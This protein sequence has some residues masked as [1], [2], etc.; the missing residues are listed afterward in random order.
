MEKSGWHE[1]DSGEELSTEHNS[2]LYV[3]IWRHYEWSICALDKKYA[4]FEVKDVG[5]I[6]FARIAKL[7]PRGKIATMADTHD[8]RSA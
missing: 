2:Y 4:T 6:S 8:T 3:S 5:S 1:E 7:S